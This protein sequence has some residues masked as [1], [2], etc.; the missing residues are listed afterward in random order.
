MAAAEQ[1]YGHSDLRTADVFLEFAEHLDSRHVEHGRFVSFSYSSSSCVTFPCTTVCQHWLMWSSLSTRSISCPHLYRLLHGVM[2]RP[3]RSRWNKAAF[4]P[5]DLLSVEA[6]SYYRKG[7]AV[8]L[9]WTSLPFFWLLFSSC[10]DDDYVVFWFGCLF[11]F[12]V[13]YGWC[14][15][16]E[17]NVW[18]YLCTVPSRPVPLLDCTFSTGLPREQ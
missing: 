18:L 14:C 2:C 9:G 4:V 16:L 3:E 12:V 15:V 5:E 7:T 17:C 1:V 6:R 11:R 13:M 8:A 10:C